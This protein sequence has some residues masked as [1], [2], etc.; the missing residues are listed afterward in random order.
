LTPLTTVARANATITT[1]CGRQWQDDPRACGRQRLDDP[2]GKSTVSALLLPHC[3]HP[4]EAAH[5][6]L[7][8]EGRGASCPG[9]EVR[10]DHLRLRPRIHAQLPGSE[11]THGYEFYYVHVLSHLVKRI[12]G[13]P[14]IAVLGAI[15]PNE[16]IFELVILDGIASRR[17]TLYEL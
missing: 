14:G 1:E 15:A 6:V 12:I 13:D 2:G 4:D 16:R 5:G 3:F 10:Q 7:L 17:S 9:Y 8:G 11:L